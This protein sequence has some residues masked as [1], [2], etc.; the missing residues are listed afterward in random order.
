MNF[1]SLFS[2]IQVHLLQ[3]VRGLIKRLVMRFEAPEATVLIVS[4][5][6]SIIHHSLY[7]YLTPWKKIK[8]PLQHSK[9]FRPNL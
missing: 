8:L 2:D 7:F 1:G 4:L 6:D 5:V 3:K 9:P